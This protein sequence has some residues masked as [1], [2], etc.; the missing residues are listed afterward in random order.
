MIFKYDFALP[1]P[2]ERAWP[3]LLDV[4]RVAPCMPGASI[5]SG[6]GDDYVGKIKVKL[7]P[8]E[9]TY[10]GDLHFTHRD[11][12]NHEMKVEGAAKDSKGGGGAKA[13]VTLKATDEDA[14]NCR[15]HINSDYSVSG[16]AAQF[17]SGLMEEVGEKLMN[18]FAA[19][20]ERL[21]LEDTASTAAAVQTAGTASMQTNQSREDAG[22]DALDIGAAAGG[23]M[24]RRALPYLAA[25][26]LLLFVLFY[27]LR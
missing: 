25:V 19:R 1:V 21:I 2:S 14:G 27:F 11:S 16:K 10:R 24:L 20:L 3:V 4:Y 9:M 5:E 7:G 15:I 8:V 22:S 17:G 26:G 6:E 12:D 23:A 18:E 13:K